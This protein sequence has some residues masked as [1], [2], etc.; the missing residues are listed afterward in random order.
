MLGALLGQIGGHRGRRVGPRGAWMPDD[1]EVKHPRRGS[2][3]VHRV[4]QS[5]S[6]PDSPSATSAAKVGA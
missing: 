1:F 6:G 5:A 2:D 3:P 4:E